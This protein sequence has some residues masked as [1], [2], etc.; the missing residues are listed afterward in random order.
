MRYGARSWN[1]EWRR[2]L[3][4]GAPVVAGREPSEALLTLVRRSLSVGPRTLGLTPRP[5][6]LGPSPQG[7]QRASRVRTPLARG[8]RRDTLSSMNE[9]FA[10][11]SL[12]HV[13]KR[14]LRL[15]VSGTYGLDEGALRHAAERG[16]NCWLWNPR[17]PAITAALQHVLRGNAEEHVVVVLGLVGYT[18]GTMRRLAENALRS[19]AVDRIDVLLLPWL[20]RASVLSR[21][22]QETLVRLKEEGKVR[23]VG[24]S[25]HDRERAAE[26]VKDS[27]LDAFMLRYN[28]KHPGAEQDIFPHLAARNPLVVAYTATSWRQLI[29][30]VSGIDMPPWPGASTTGAPPPPLTAE[31]CYRFCLSSPHVHVVWTAP[32]TRQQ[33]DENLG[34]LRAGPLSTEE[35]AWVREYGAK[36]KAKKRFTYF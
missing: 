32:K 27:V 4:P 9:T 8:L 36:V 18:G 11:A 5:V 33:L 29:R 26:L 35:E 22:V 23:A 21:G 3:P 1:R 13:E 24:T 30:P 31:L 34:A 28:A 14:A 25:I 17:Y 19:L 7:A 15:G 10:Y 20:G 6:R 16:V 12:P 2:R